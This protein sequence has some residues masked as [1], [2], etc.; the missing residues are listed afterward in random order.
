MLVLV[1]FVSA[2]QG[3]RSGMIEVEHL[4]D[5]QLQEQAH[6]AT[7]VESSR[8]ATLDKVANVAFQQWRLVPGEAPVLLAHTDNIPGIQLV[9]LRPGFAYANFERYRWRTYVH[10]SERGDIVVVAAARTDIRYRLADDVIIESITPVVLWLPLSGL[11]IWLIVGRGL[12]PLGE[13]ANRLHAK[14]SRDL[15]AIVLER[16]PVELESVVDSVNRLLGRLHQAFE[17]ERRFV[18]DAA[19]ELRTPIAVLRVQ[20][21]NIRDRLPDHAVELQ[22]LEVGVERMQHLVEQILMLHRLSPEQLA[23]RFVPIDLHALLQDAVAAGYDAIDARE[24]HVELVADAAASQGQA[25]VMGDRFALQTL[26][27]NLLD[28][29]I[30]YTPTGGH[31]RIGVSCTGTAVVLD[32]EDDGPGISLL[33]RE[34]I[35]ERFHRVGGDGHASGEIGCGLGLAIVRNIVELHGAGIEVGDSRFAGGAR[36]TVVFQRS[37]VCGS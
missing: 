37:S 25:W 13:L 29:A 8:L 28:N 27:R 3:Y 16:C 2:V 26:V 30:K 9:A 31:I 11:L 5:S 14:E 34:R 15:S 1:V 18:A 22:A 24:Q 6:L 17:R 35:F 23:G 20:V 7:V 21:H 10:Y 33:A 4:F 32:V 19:H 12:S 36:F